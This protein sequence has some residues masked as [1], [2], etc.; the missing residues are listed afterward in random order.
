[1]N[2]VGKAKEFSDRYVDKR[3]VVSG[4]VATLAAGA[5]LT[6]MMKS[7]I[8]PLVSVAKAAK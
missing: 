8:K 7:K 4:V 2:P 5:L 3:M 1:M 6:F